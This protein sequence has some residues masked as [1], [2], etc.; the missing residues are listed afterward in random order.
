MDYSSFGLILLL[1]SL[2]RAAPQGLS[3]CGQ[4]PANPAAGQIAAQYLQIPGCGGSSAGGSS[5]RV[6]NGTGSGFNDGSAS[7]SA[8]ASIALA[9]PQQPST[10]ATAPNSSGGKCPSGFRN[11]VFN[12]GAS[13]NAGW[14]QTT[15]N[16]LTSN[17]VDDWSKSES[18]THWNFIQTFTDCDFT[19]S[20]LCPRLSRHHDDL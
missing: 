4:I 9:T 14:P 7:T 6:V 20:R 16:S 10:S 11:A 18:A 19:Y 3:A 5:N 1:L 17:G 13:K 2:V 12:T 8:T 15:W